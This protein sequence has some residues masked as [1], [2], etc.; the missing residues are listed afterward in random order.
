MMYIR[1]PLSL[2]QVEDLL[3]ERG[4]DIVLER[5]DV[6]VVTSKGDR[7]A[8]TSLRV[9]PNAVTSAAL[10]RAEARAIAS[11]NSL[12]EAESALN[13]RRVEVASVR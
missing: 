12:T 1:Y 5:P 8:T 3:F 6:V 2:R 11:A 9:G 4:I 7:L 13:L 10:E